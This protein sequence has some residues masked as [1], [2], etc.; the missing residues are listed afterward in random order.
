MK[1]TFVFALCCALAAFSCTQKVD[2]SIEAPQDE[3]A[4]GKVVTISAT[5]SDEL[6]KVAFDPTYDGGKPT[7]LALAWA[8]GDQI[9]IYN[10]ADRSKYE[11]FTLAEGSVG[12]QKGCFSGETTKLA[13]ATAFDVEVIGGEGFDY[14]SQ[15]QPADGVTTDLKYLASV[16][17]IA[18]YSTIEFTSFNSVLAITA[19]M[20]SI[21]AAAAVKSVDITA[22]ADI[23]AGGNTLTITLETPGSEDD[24]LNFYA[25]LPQGDQAIVAGTT[26]IVKFNAP[27]TDHTV[28]TRY[29]ELP[30]S[31][32]TSKKLNT[33]NINASNSA[34]Y[35]NAST[36]SIGTES[37]PYLIGDAYQLAAINGYASTSSTTYI[38]MVSDVDMTGVT[39]TPINKS[40][41]GYKIVV[42]FDGNNKTISNLKTHLFYVFKGSIKDLT[43]DN[44]STTSRGLFAEFC[45]GTGHSMT[46][47]SITNG[48]ITSSSA[49]TGGLI[50]RINNGTAGQTTVT[51][52]DCSVSDT[53]V[54]VNQKDS[55]D[56]TCNGG[57]IGSA[58]D[59]VVL[60]GCR[61]SGGT[62]VSYGAYV[63]GLIGKLIGD[64]STVTNCYATG[65]VTSTA[66][67]TYCYTGG[68]IGLINKGVT[69]QRCYA[70]CVITVNKA[71]DGAF[72]GLIDASGTA[73]S[74]TNC[75]ASGSLTAAGCNY[76]GGFVG[77][78]QSSIAS[79]SVTNCY[80]NSNISGKNDNSTCPFAGDDRFEST[81][82][83][84]FVGWSAKP[85][86]SYSK[87]A[88]PDGN[89]IG[90]GTGEGDTIKDHAIGYGWN[91]SIW[92]LGSGDPDAPTLN[93]NYVEP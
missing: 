68:L 23:F 71:G 45:Q 63:G 2:I 79:L 72:I 15:T 25:T 43:L 56:N 48:T 40:V 4:A 30:A 51:I 90:T 86:W 21:A 85:N 27:G 14:A 75:Y 78:I 52:T 55:K 41:S 5:L 53:D 88:C 1:K 31:T 11:D 89:Y 32:F 18:D 93:P 92:N 26:L 46:N 58:E 49:Y 12:Q 73:V 3:P 69:I 33:I 35:A 87:T 59:K 84:G 39:H 19:K 62:V 64:G 57:F 70:S 47:V 28:Y 81:S 24:I 50:G 29:I 34:S 91:S 44:S 80:T 38:K 60:S 61:F 17:N 13:G 67:S 7:S 74:I 77:L 20:P 82:C 42:D 10:N 22:S 65:N 54:T 8:A 66:T 6:T 16:T 76:I 37:N 36:A 83:S 9:R